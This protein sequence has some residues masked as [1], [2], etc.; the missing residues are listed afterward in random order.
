[1]P[2]RDTGLSTKRARDATGGG[3]YN[4]SKTRNNAAPVSHERAQR[5]RTANE[6]R[7]RRGMGPSKKTAPK[8]LDRQKGGRRQGDVGRYE[9]RKRLNAEDAWH[10]AC[11]AKHDA[12]VSRIEAEIYGTDD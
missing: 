3:F 1:M 10:A 9:R 5:V 4:S 2:R 6:L 8:G 11:R 12:N 7:E